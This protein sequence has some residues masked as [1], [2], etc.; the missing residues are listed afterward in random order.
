VDI[1]ERNRREAEI[2]QPA[3]EREQLWVNEQ[4]AR[5][6]AE[7]ANH[8][9]D[10]F[11]A[12]VSHEL[13]TPLTSI[14]GWVQMLR[15]GALAPEKRIRALDTIE[16]NARSQA[17]LI[18]DLLD[19]SRIMSNKLELELEPTDMAGVVAA[20]VETVRPVAQAKGVVLELSIEAG[21]IVNGDT[22]RLQQVVWNLLSNAV[23]FTPAGGRVHAE[24]PSGG[25]KRG[26]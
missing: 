21:G 14:L 4:Q 9:K 26:P 1:T 12:M 8:L 2:H 11:L 17:Q 16:R 22:E 6:Q 15:S 18:G 20:S 5:A 7:Q 13:R 3:T 24:L 10:E 19:V 25:W 23:K